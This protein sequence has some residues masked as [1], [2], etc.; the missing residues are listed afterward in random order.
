MTR[1]KKEFSKVITQQNDSY[2]LEYQTKRAS[3]PKG[4]QLQLP[5]FTAKTTMNCSQQLLQRKATHTSKSHLNSHVQSKTV[6]SM[7]L[8]VP[9]IRQ[10]LP[11]NPPPPPQ[12]GHDQILSEEQQL[13][14]GRS[15]PNRRT[16]TPLRP[17]TSKIVNNKPRPTLTNCNPSCPQTQPKR[18]LP[19]QQA[20]RHAR[21]HPSQARSSLPGRIEAPVPVVCAARPDCL[22]EHAPV[23]SG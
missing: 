9:S 3:P 4:E 1:F 5:A 10:R 21:R 13:H 11:H 22:V 8:N 18:S 16:T 12:T 6:A 23:L 19:V 14:R 7:I 15:H 2:Y 17:F 20:T